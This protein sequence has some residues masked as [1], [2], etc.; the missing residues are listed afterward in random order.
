MGNHGTPWPFKIKKG[1]Y[2]LK[3]ILGSKTII[4][5]KV[6]LNE[7]KTMM[8]ATPSKPYSVKRYTSYY[9]STTPHSKK[10]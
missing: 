3:G 9:P 5:V 1:I 10:T 8:Y 4:S 2:T 7:R 6:A